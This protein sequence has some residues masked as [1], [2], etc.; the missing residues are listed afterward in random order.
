M[1]D[2]PLKNMSSSVGMMKFPIYG[3]N[4]NVPNH[5]PGINYTGLKVDLRYLNQPPL[6]SPTTAANPGP[7]D[8]SGRTPWLPEGP[9]CR[10]CREV[11]L[12]TAALAP[13]SDMVRWGREHMVII[14]SM[15]YGYNL[16]LLI[17]IY[18]LW[19]FNIAMEAMAHRNRLFSQL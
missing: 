11:D 5:Q 16:N 13:S 7:C 12:S 2:L 8:T 18:T 1:V 19:L 15:K 10:W 6:L 9:P 3:Q 4:K 17:V 14:I